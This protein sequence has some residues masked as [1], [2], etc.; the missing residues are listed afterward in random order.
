MKEGR[1]MFLLRSNPA[2]RPL[3][4]VS[5]N[6][7]EKKTGTSN[8]GID[9]FYNEIIDNRGKIIV[10]HLKM[11]AD[12]PGMNKY[13]QEMVEDRIEMTENQLETVE[14]RLEMTE[15]Q[16]ETVEDQPEMV[17][18]RVEMTE[19]QL[20]TVEDQLEMVEDQL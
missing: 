18:D 15:N 12:Y 4:S 5:I 17:E 1:P 11:D 2:G 7:M 8:T 14:D 6:K 19:N 20:E 16:L 13:R 3:F 10:N 9:K